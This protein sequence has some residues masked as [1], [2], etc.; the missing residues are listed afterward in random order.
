MKA[1]VCCIVHGEAGTGKS[2]VCGTTPAPRLILDAEGGARFVAANLPAIDWDPLKEPVP[3]WDGSWNSVFVNVHDWATLIAAYNVVASGNHDFKSVILD[4]LTEA[5]KRLVD[6]VSGVDQP[7]MQDWGTILRY[8]EDLVRKFRDLTFHPTHPI[9]AVIMTCLSHLRDDRTRP[10]LKGQLELTLPSFVDVVGYMHTGIDATT[11]QVDY[12]MLI[13]PANNIIAKDR[14]SV[15]TQ[16][17]GSV[18]IN[19]DVTEWIALVQDLYD[20]TTI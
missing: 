3:R 20:N 9:E 13:A 2:F 11:N 15:I 1:A 10:F 6:N 16:K 14:T 19:A 8:L 5:Q 12:R 4:S 7:T 18:L 17:H